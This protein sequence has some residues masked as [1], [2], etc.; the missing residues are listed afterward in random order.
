MYEVTYHY[1][2]SCGEDDQKY[3]IFEVEKGC[4]P[5][6][7]RYVTVSEAHKEEPIAIYGIKGFSTICQNELNSNYNMVSFMGRDVHRKSWLTCLSYQE[8]DI[9]FCDIDTMMG[10][11]H[12]I[13]KYN[14]LSGW[15]LKKALQKYIKKRKGIC[16]TGE[17]IPENDSNWEE[18]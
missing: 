9:F 15:R 11:F 7:L 16:Y 6:G 1:G 8:A 18:N 2:T 5:Q 10:S 4:I 13:R 12:F 14:K 3:S 17:Q